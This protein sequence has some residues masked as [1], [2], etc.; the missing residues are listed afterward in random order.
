MGEGARY[1]PA[2]LDYRI[3]LG[4]NGNSNTL[5]M[6]M[7]R[8]D[9]VYINEY[10]GGDLGQLW[11]HD[12][13]E[14]MVDGD[15]TGGDYSGYANENWSDGQMMLNGNRTA[16]LDVAVADTPDGRH[17]GYLGAGTEWVNALPY[18][19]GGGGSYVWPDDLDLR[20]LCHSV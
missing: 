7:E 15:H 9:D 13:I 6:A 14:F 2:D 17:V 5:H 18:A 10:S 11:R 16:Q 19:D 3:W 1:D 12:A 8:V 4:W 20:V